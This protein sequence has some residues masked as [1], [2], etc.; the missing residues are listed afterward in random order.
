MDEVQ[1]LPCHLWSLVNATISELAH[2]GQFRLLA[3]SATQTG[4]LS[5]SVE[6]IPNLPSVYSQLSRYEIKLRISETLSID[7]FVD[8]LISRASSWIDQRVLIVLNTR[9]SARIVRDALCKCACAIEFIT[10]DVTP[11]DRLSAIQ[12]IKDGNP[13]LVVAT[14][15]IEAG[16]DI[17]MSLVIRD[18]APLDSVIQVAGRCNRNADRDRETVEVVHLLNKTGKPFSGM[19]YDKIL[20]QE[21][22]RALGAE[23]IQAGGLKEENVFPVAKAYFAAI[24]EKKNLG[25]VYTKAFSQW[26][27]FPSVQELLRGKRSEQ[28]TFV[29]VEQDPSLSDDL[30]NVSRIEDRWQR[31]RALRQLSSRIAAVSVSVYARNVDDPG[32]FADKDGT[33]NFWLLKRGYYSSDRGLSLFEDHEENVASSWGTIL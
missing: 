15:C 7:A 14:Q 17:D 22:H 6:I 1:A 27:E 23:M 4:F 25:D 28:F 5:N 9:K 11:R 33:G 21:T 30:T 3:M 31:R 32:R 18:F 20:L 19:I 24:A 26:E 8:E 12:R 13:C 2:F 10:A 16:V 29:V